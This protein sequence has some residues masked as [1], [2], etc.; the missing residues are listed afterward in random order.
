MRIVFIVII[1]ALVGLGLWFT[2]QKTEAPTETNE[3]NEME[4]LPENTGEVS[5]TESPMSEEGD[6]DAPEGSDVGMEFPVPDDEETTSSVTVV[7]YTDNGFSP[8]TIT[9][10]AG[11]TVQ[12]VNNSTRGM[13]V[14]VDNHPTHTLYDG[15]S[16]S[17]HCGDSS[18]TFDQCTA[19]DP[20]TSWEFTFDK[21]GTFGY[22]NHVRAND[23]GT[24]IVQ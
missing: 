8:D 22:H 17:E 13:W 10:A 15:T 14:G 19:S 12:F 3:E 11:E 4:N 9:V 2:T 24:V 7:T 18:N 20:G 21:T 23:G 16:R 6:S 1:V 5:D